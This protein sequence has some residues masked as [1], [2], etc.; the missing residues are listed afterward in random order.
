MNIYKIADGFSMATAASSTAYEIP[1]NMR[2]NN[3]RNN[4]GAI[5]LVR[6]SGSNSP[7]VK[8]Q[9]SVDGTNWVDILAS[10]TISTAAT[11]SLYPFM[12]ITVT[13][14]AASTNASFFI[15]A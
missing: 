15:V 1:A 6:T 3:N 7:T 9:G 11:V 14:T 10:I 5:Q 8:L 2:D 4:V 12:R 13:T